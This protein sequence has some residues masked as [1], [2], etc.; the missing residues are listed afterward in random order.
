MK[1]FQWN[2]QRTE[3]PL[4]LMAL[5]GD[6]GIATRK[7]AILIADG[8]EAASVEAESP[9]NV[10]S[11]LRLPESSKQP[12]KRAIFAIEIVACAYLDES[13]ASILDIV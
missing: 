9:L 7:V 1:G 11:D 8:V 13:R 4:S 5:P 6:G 2:L 3:I 12:S 10:G